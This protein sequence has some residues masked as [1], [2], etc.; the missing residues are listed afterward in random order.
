MHIYKEYIHFKSK[1]GLVLSYVWKYL[2]I[3]I[4]RDDLK[5]KYFSKLAKKYPV[6][7]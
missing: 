2:L 3:K 7:H 5:T 1:E 4:V 6:E